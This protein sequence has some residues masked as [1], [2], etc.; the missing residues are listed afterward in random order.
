MS[1]PGP[2]QLEL[3]RRYARTLRELHADAVRARGPRMGARE[4]RAATRTAA[5]PIIEAA[6]TLAADA[7]AMAGD[8]AA[9]GR[10]PSAPAS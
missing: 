7:R 9:K 8:V 5:E 3:I 1:E 10:K 4:A 2:A 6:K